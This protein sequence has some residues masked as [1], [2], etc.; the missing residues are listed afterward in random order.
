LDCPQV[1]FGV[2]IIFFP[3]FSWGDHLH[4]HKVHCVNDL[5]GALVAPIIIVKFLLNYHPFFLETISANNLIHSYS[6]LTWSWC[7]I[8][9][10]DVVV[11][12][13]PFL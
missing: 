4:F 1:P 7:E 8:F 5:F 6:K 9:P 13:L 12:I 10:L 2:L 11:C 3:Y